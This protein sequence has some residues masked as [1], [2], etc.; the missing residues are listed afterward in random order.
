MNYY[1]ACSGMGFE[2]VVRGKD[3]DDAQEKAD[4]IGYDIAL[5]LKQSD[6]EYIFN[7]LPKSVKV[8]IAKKVLK[9]E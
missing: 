3:F 8:R 9:N 5:G 7:T 2:C 1:L 6:L 4:A